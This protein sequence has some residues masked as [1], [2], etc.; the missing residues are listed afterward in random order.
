MPNLREARIN[1]HW[2]RVFNKNFDLNIRKITFEN[3][4][5]FNGLV[6]KLQ[7]G[8]NFLVGKN[9]VGKTNLVQTIFNTFY[10]QDNSNR[11]RF[12]LCFDPGSISVE[13]KIRDSIEFFS[14][15]KDF[16][17]D[18]PHEIDVFMYNPCTLIPELHSLFSSQ[19]NL[20]ELLEGFTEKVLNAN[21]LILINYLTKS[22]YQEVKLISIEGEFEK[23]PIVPFF[24]VKVRNIEYDSLTMGLGEL[25]L[26]YFFWLL[27][28]IYK[29]EAISIL[30]VEE[31]ES[32][33]PPAH[34]NNLINLLIRYISKKRFTTIIS[35]H[36][37]HILKKVPR[38]NIQILFR[39]NDLI[40]ST[41]ISDKINPLS[42]LGLNSPKIGVLIYEDLAAELFIKSIIRSS[43]NF[44]VD[45]FFYEKANSASN[46]ITIL[47]SISK[48]LDYF[49]IIGIFDSDFQNNVSELRR[50][51]DKN[52]CFLP[53][54]NLPPEILMMNYFISTSNEE[55]ASSLNFSTEKITFAKDIASGSNHHD[56]F[57]LISNFLE[58]RFEDVF[59]SVCD[60]W[61]LEESNRNY[62]EQF[63]SKLQQIFS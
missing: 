23:Y 48:N 36:S 19:K 35:T 20:H 8:I 39:D 30:I 42:I 13:Y 28:Y 60:L 14:T 57:Y 22:E 37:E 45:G 41:S 61:I 27:E 49:K 56:Y 51:E 3:S 44:V 38:N 55:L 29:N 17:D 11:L 7:P 54:N 15:D 24:K 10:T 34:Q 43:S 21:E 16:L 59:L 63:L 58:K 32:F 47:S 50:I 4:M 25:S 6:L 40:K 31:L 26:F 18:F 33:L 1:D 2:R 5:Y 46:I 52:Y 53:A 62:A 12:D 9:G